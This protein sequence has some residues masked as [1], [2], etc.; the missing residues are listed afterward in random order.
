MRSAPLLGCDDPPQAAQHCHARPRQ[1]ARVA[2]APAAGTSSA[3]SSSRSAR[4]TLCCSRLAAT[5]GA[6]TSTATRA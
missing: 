5:I 2:P 4:V 6:S 1:P 3:S